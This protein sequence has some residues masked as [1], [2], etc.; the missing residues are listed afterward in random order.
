MRVGAALAF[1]FTPSS[2]AAQGTEARPT[3]GS[4]VHGVVPVHDGA[5][6][7]SGAGQLAYHAGGSVQTGTHST[8]A[9]YWNPNNGAGTYSSGYQST[10]NGYFSDVAADSGKSTNVY[11]S[12]T[13]Y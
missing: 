6:R 12:D 11:D 2:H 3:N 4:G 8:Y 1:G 7:G 5:V 13:Q 9:I 10:I